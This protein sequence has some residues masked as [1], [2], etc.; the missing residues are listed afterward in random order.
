MR[1]TPKLAFTTTAILVAVGLLWVGF[2][3]GG[4]GQISDSLG[5]QG[6]GVAGQYPNQFIAARTMTAPAVP[7]FADT[8][9]LPAAPKPQDNVPA[10]ALSGSAIASLVMLALAFARFQSIHP[11]VNPAVGSET[12]NPRR[13]RLVTSGPPQL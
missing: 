3:E 2:V 6:A 11:G 5:S 8:G 12:A 10:L 13:A 7:G 9:A 1:I 4:R